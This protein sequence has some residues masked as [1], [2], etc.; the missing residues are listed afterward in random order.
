MQS[1]N[2]NSK[3]IFPELS[4]VVTGLCYKVH[5]ELGRFSKEKQYCDSLAQKLT[6][7]KIPFK[8][9]LRAYEFNE[10][11][12]FII[13]DKIIFEAKAKRILLPEDYFQVQRYLQHLD[14]PLGLLVNFWCKFI[15]PKRIV[16]IE[17]DARKK[18][19]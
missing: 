1:T 17:T 2:K 11:P 14:Y 12:D 13:D 5:N 8:R 16:K 15:D 6:E 19:L 3:L 10:L 7:E 4:Y 9:E 18:Y